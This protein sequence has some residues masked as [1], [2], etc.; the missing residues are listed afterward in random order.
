MDEVVESVQQA[1]H[2][3]GHEA[4]PAVVD[5]FAEIGLAGG[6]LVQNGRLLRTGEE[7]ELVM[8]RPL[9][10]QLDRFARQAK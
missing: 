9:R 10:R 4:E 8:E 3:L 1:Q 7:L 2:R 5:Q 6:I